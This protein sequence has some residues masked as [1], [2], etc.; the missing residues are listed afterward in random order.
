[1]GLVISLGIFLSAVVVHEFAHALV[2]RRLGDTTAERLGR[3][4]LN[5]LAHIDPIGTILLPV[6]LVVTHAPIVLG[7]AKPVPI[8]FRQLG[9][10]KRDMIWVGL[11]GPAANF[12]AAALS[13]LIYRSL[14]GANASLVGLILV[15][16]ILI[17]ITLGTFNLIP[18]P[19]LDG[20]R[21]LVGLLPMS[22]ARPYLRME[23]YGF[24]IVIGLLYV[25]AFDRII[26]PI[27]EGA[28]KLLAPS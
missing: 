28:F 8:D 5:P 18:I 10:P 21:V 7:W 23:R 15:S 11:A 22:M 25:G 2:A 4:T 20:S 17:N 13:A 3:L 16:F 9:H 1:M 26:G 24:L 27:I 12:L 14:P 19:P 6:L